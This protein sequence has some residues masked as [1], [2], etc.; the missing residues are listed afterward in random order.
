MGSTRLYAYFS[1]HWILAWLLM[2]ASFV[3]FGLLSLNLL[4]TLNANLGFLAAHGVDAVRE[5]GLIQLGELVLSGY[6]AVACY[7]AFKFCEKVLVERLA[8]ERRKENDQ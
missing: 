4:H 7:V 5:G 3:L 1:R 8:L 6:L 2:G